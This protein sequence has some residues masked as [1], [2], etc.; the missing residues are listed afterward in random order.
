[1]GSRGR[2]VRSPGGPAIASPRESGRATDG[3]GSLSTGPADCRRAGSPRALAG[4]DTLAE[5]AQARQRCLREAAALGSQPFGGSDCRELGG[6]VAAAS[7]P[8]TRTSAEG[9]SAASEARP[10]RA[11]S[12]RREPR[13]KAPSPRRRQLRLCHG[14]REHSPR[15]RRSPVGISAACDHGP[16]SHDC[17][18]PAGA[19]SSRFPGTFN[20]RTDGPRRYRRASF[21]PA[22]RAFA[23]GAVR[24][25]AAFA[26]GFFAVEGFA[27]AGLHHVRLR[28]RRLPPT[29]SREPASPRPSSRGRRPGGGRGSPRA[30]RSG[31][32]RAGRAAAGSGD[33]RGAPP[34]RAASPA[35]RAARAPTSRAPRGRAPG[36]RS[37]GRRRP[38]RPRRARRPPRG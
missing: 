23:A 27:A 12:G 37:P 2:P 22:E 15:P 29:P 3:S 24:R 28:A 4:A 5:R 25:G 9:G 10:P 35:R 8:G 18:G 6:D 16:A 30:P 26:A 17:L 1:M 20:T 14:S 32:G 21:F 34:T 38:A 31:R 13:R 36:A 33:R 7:G 19:K 11:S